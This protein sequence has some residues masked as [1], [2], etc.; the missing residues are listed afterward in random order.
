MAKVKDEFKDMVVKNTNEDIG[1]ILGHNSCE[2]KYFTI[3]NNDLIY[4]RLKEE[5]NI[6]HLPILGPSVDFGLG[7]VCIEECFE[8]GKEIFK[9]YL[10]DRSEK[11][12]CEEFDCIEAVINKLVD[13]YASWEVDDPVSMRN[14]FYETLNLQKNNKKLIKK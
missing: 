6:I 2:L 5:T 9:F 8:N 1:D 10:I 11:Y 7:D 3:E 13:F 4:K 12:D 14:I